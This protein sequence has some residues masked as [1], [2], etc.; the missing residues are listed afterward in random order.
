MAEHRGNGHGDGHHARPIPTDPMG[1]HTQ[2]ARRVYIPQPDAGPAV[3][4]AVARVTRQFVY[5][6][7]LDADVITYRDRSVL[8]ELGHNVPS[9]LPVAMWPRP[10]STSTTAHR[11][12]H[13]Q[14]QWATLREHAVR[15]GE[16]RIRDANGSYRWFL[17]R[18][19]VMS[20]A[21]R[22]HRLTRAWCADRHDRDGKQ[23]M[24][25]LRERDVDITELIEAHYADYRAEFLRPLADHLAKLARWRLTPLLCSPTLTIKRRADHS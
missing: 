5:V 6:F 13:L 15:E 8:S 22:R 10:A 17:A 25:A 11:L 20:A 23:A 2:Q 7:S 12:R 1:G 9:D 21:C 3:L 14:L 19:T 16:C 4:D 18:E 24:Q